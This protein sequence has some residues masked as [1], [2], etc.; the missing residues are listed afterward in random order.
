MSM[1][2]SRSGGW[3]WAWIAAA[4]ISVGVEVA[5]ALRSPVPY[6]FVRQAIS[7]LGMTTCG[8]V[9]VY[10]GGPVEVCSPWWGVVAAGWVST[11]LLI[12][13]GAWALHRVLGLGRAAAW[14]LG[15]AGLLY[16][17]VGAV[18][19]D[20]NV[21]LHALLGVLGF[22]VQ[23]V[24]MV[25]AGLALRRRRPLL[26]WLGLAGGALGLVATAVLFVPS[27]Q[28]AFGLIE[29]VSVYP[30]SVWLAVAG[31]AAVRASVADQI[32]PSEA[33]ARA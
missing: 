14:L 20:V 11:G 26:G 10:L 21:G 24:A 7:D 8:S 1:S 32:S 25:V 28:E 12:A 29:R 13:V 27:T 23:N 5:A 15:V 33:S 30:F 3:G 19:A 4:V 6:S 31:W 18:P 2:P 22:V 17:A 16:S 9:D